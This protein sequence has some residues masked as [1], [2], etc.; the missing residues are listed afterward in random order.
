MPAGDER[1]LNAGLLPRSGWT[2]EDFRMIQL[3]PSPEPASSVLR[4]PPAIFAVALLLGAFAV[5]GQPGAQ[6]G[7]PHEPQAVA[8]ALQR[9]GLRDPVR[10]Q[11][12]GGV[13]IA[14][15]AAVDGSRYRAV[16]DARTG[17]LTGLRPL[18]PA[19]VDAR[20][21]VAS[22]ASGE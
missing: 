4:R 18:P 9:H 11:R 17:E 3:Q 21:G 2:C 20:H 1:R 10:L 13:W 14:E 12:R 5:A 6:H 7:A 15:V 22:A 8:N 19:S 16:V